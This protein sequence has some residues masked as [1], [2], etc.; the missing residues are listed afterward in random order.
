VPAYIF[1]DM[2]DAGKGSECYVIC[3][4][5]RRIAAITVAERVAVERGD[6]IGESVGFQ[7]RLH[8]R[9]G[10]KTRILFCTTGVLLRKLQQTDFLAS[11]SHIVIDEVHERQVETGELKLAA[12]SIFLFQTFSSSTDKRK[13][14]YTLHVQTF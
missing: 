14:H 5:P 8:S 3:T 11:V 2:I 12:M 7:V 6:K 1:E 13:Y 10:P 4:Q 9:C